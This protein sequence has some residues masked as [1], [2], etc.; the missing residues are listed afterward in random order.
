[1]PMPSFPVPW[2][3]GRTL[4][5]CPWTGLHCASWEGRPVPSCL[6]ILPTSG[7]LPPAPCLPHMVIYYYTTILTAT[8]GGGCPLHSP[9][10][11]PPPPYPHSVS[12]LSLPLWEE[13]LPT[14]A[15]CL[16]PFPACLWRRAGSGQTLALDSSGEVPSH[17]QV[18]L[19]LGIL[20]S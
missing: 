19:C 9:L 3:R 4:S 20:G 2:R 14:M 18:V 13:D 10:A 1:M 5:P 11:L 6:A 12:L 8:S 15:P 16:P 17:L 7:T